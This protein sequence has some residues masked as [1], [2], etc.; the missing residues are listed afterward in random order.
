MTKILIPEK[1]DP[2]CPK[3]FEDAGF[4]VH[5][6]QNLSTEE[7]NS[8]IGDY[9]GLVVRSNTKV[10]AEVLAKASKLKVVG[11]AGAGV[12]TIDVAAATAQKILVMNT[13]GQN[14]NAVA[15]LAFGFMLALMRHIVSGCVSTKGGKWEK[16]TLAGTELFGKTIGVVGFG[17]IGRRVGTLATSFGMTVLAHDPML[18]SDQIKASGGT[19]ST[20]EEILAQSDVVTLHIPKTPETAKLL[21]RDNIAKM[22]QGSYLINCARGG[23]VD[24]IALAD[25]LKSGHLAGAALDVF[26]SEP[27]AADNP[28]LA[29]NNFLTTPH[30]GASTAEAQVNVAVAVAKQMISFFQNGTTEGAVNK[31]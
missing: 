23:L 30:L 12:D 21:S 18:T 31:V 10:T 16:K 9:D 26:D 2:I 11:R 1:I 6:H 14:A 3:I 15:E 22:K 25:A 28:L 8:M 17:A 7:L 27:P 13:P 19:P 20:V 29:L 5:Y 24:E 4:E